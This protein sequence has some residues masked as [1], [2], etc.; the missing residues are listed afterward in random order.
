M[1]MQLTYA[2]QRLDQIGDLQITSR[3]AFEPAHAPQRV[4]V[5]LNVVIDIFRDNYHD[6]QRLRETLSTALRKQ[7]RR[8]LWKNPNSSVPTGEENYVDRIA[9][10]VSEDLPEDPNAW[11]TKYQKVNVVFQYI[12][13]LTNNNQ[14]NNLLCY[15]TPDCEV[16]VAAEDLGQVHSFGEG[17]TTERFSQ[18]NDERRRT[19]GSVSISGRFIVDQDDYLSDRRN[20]LESKRNAILTAVGHKCGQ[21]TYGLS[22]D[23]DKFFDE[24]VRIT[25]FDLETNEAV[26]GIDWSLEAEWTKFPDESTFST[27]EYSVDSQEERGTGQVRRT[28]SGTIQAKERATADTALTTLR[29]DLIAEWAVAQG[30]FTPKVIE[31]SKSSNPSLVES[32]DGDTFVSLDFNETYLIFGNDSTGENE[33]RSAVYAVSVDN[34]LVESMKT[35]TITGTLFGGKEALK[36]CRDRDTDNYL[37]KL[38]ERFDVA[39]ETKPVKWD[40]EIDYEYGTTISGANPSHWGSLMLTKDMDGAN[41]R[42]QKLTF[43]IS[44]EERIE[45]EGILESEIRYEQQFSGPRYVIHDIPGGVS[46]AQDTGTMPG[47]NRLSGHV[48][49]KDKSTADS[50]AEN[51]ISG[52]MPNMPLRRAPKYNYTFTFPRRT[53]G[54]TYDEITGQPDDDDFVGGP[55]HHAMASNQKSVKLTFDVEEIVLNAPSSV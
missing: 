44:F 8:L 9:T 25:S 49:A 42:A 18:Y 51:R 53:D 11:G 30:T 24:S 7:H 22:S 32:E 14:T 15:F 27:V 38:A 5:T 19:S 55:P 35:T 31:V 40:T 6:A 50:Y 48:V 41:D 39:M 46:V 52:L 4:V 45:E 12:E 33:I 13:N 21:L 34:D 1:S 20:A 54:V 29:N 16:P 23:T 37:S 3:R 28:I 17:Y 43:T 10:V 47:F 26:N 36:D 2:G